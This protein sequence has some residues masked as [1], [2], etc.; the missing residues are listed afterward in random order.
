MIELW[1]TRHRGGTKR[2]RMT[3]I[4]Q[5][6]Q[7]GGAKTTPHLIVNAVKYYKTA[8]TRQIGEAVQIRRRNERGSILNS[9]A[10]YDRCHIPYPPPNG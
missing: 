10:E 1:S 9:K 8:S 4:S 6:S 5:I 7:H 2:R 3:S